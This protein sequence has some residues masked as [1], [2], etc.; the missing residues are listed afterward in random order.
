MSQHDMLPFDMTDDRQSARR[1]VNVSVRATG[2]T[3]RDAQQ[4]QRQ[5]IAGGQ[6]L[7][8]DVS[9]STTA[10][11]SST[12]TRRPS[13][14]SS[15]ACAMLRHTKQQMDATNGPPPPPHLHVAG[16][17]GAM[18]R[19]EMEQNYNDTQSHHRHRR[20][21]S[22]SQSPNRSQR[23]HHHHNTNNYSGTSSRSSS[24][25]HGDSTS[26]NGTTT[27]LPNGI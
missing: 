6:P 11:T 12:K 19:Q 20:S 24:I 4:D 7:P 18:S 16:P 13:D 5:H 26:A 15:Y 22:Q 14:L 10:A 3:D 21:G 9:M 27:T 8:P 2:Q 17:A 25:R 23:H 1:G